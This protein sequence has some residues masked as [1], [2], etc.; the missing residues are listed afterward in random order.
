MSAF[1]STSK[2]AQTSVTNGTDNNGYS[3]LSPH[4]MNPNGYDTP[5]QQ[6]INPEDE[7]MND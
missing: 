1:S 7:V 3:L 5:L 4:P 6:P 2:D